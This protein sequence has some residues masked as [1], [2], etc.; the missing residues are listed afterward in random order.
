MTLEDIAKTQQD[1]VQAAKNAIEAGF[2]GVELHAANSYLFEQFM[3]KS[4][5]QRTDEY[6]GSQENRIRFLVE[7]VT[8]V[9]EA[10]GSEKTAFRQSPYIMVDGH[11]VDPEAPELTLKAL[12]ALN[13]LDLA[14]VHFSENVTNW[15]PVPTSFRRKVRNVW[16][17][18]VIVAGR[19]N[20]E[21]AED[22]V[23]QHFA[24]L[25]AFGE[26]FIANPDLVY[27]F[28]ENLPLNDGNRTTYYGGSEEGLL[29]YPICDPVVKA[30]TDSH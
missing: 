4:S 28:K 9:A 2:D 11:D 18:G 6:G 3:L 24:D 29:D 26:F 5:N 7:T 15:R 12:A 14:Y 13:H 1:F 30:L 25:V 8:K 23:E 22:I 10:I 20:K 17:H 27:R 19:Y 16:N 21:S